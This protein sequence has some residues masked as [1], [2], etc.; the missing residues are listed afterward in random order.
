MI[1]RNQS[2][3][4]RAPGPQFGP[5]APV[6]TVLSRTPPQRS[7]TFFTLKLWLLIFKHP[8]SPHQSAE[9]SEKALEAAGNAAGERKSAHSTH[10]PT[11]ASD[12]IGEAQNV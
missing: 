2:H 4:V 8:K 10:P 12:A 7:P 5:P 11:S 3:L 9:K 1:G 6:E